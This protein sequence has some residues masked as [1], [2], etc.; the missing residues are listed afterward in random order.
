[1]R[2]PFFRKKELVPEWYA[3]A[4]REGI[5]RKERSEVA[6][7]MVAVKGEGPLSHEE[8]QKGVIHFGASECFSPHEKS[9]M[10]NL[11]PSA[12]DCTQFTWR[13]ESLN[14]LLWFLGFVPLLIRPDKLCDAGHVVKF[15]GNLQKAGLIEK[16]NRRSPCELLDFTDL[17]FRYHWAVRDAQL[18]GHAVPAGLHSGV[19]YERHYALNWL[20]QGGDWDSVDTST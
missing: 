20:V 12:Q 7:T 1:M 17:S 3:N 14:V 10:D 4:P 15:L 9:F 2:F 8:I 18:R 11:S 16:A 19:V 13:Y 5:E 6:L